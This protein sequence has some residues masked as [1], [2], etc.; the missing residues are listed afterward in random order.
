MTKQFHYH[1]QDAL[2]AAKAFAK[3]NGFYL[4]SQEI[5]VDER[6]MSGCDYM[7]E[8]ADNLCW[9]GEVS[10]LVVEDDDFNAAGYF[11][12]WE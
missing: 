12:Y 9:S 1:Y 8:R 2:D 3:E 11:A 7:D 6:T 10:A 4:S 5:T